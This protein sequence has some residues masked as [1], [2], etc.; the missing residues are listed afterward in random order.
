MKA[1][2]LAG[3]A[4]ISVNAEAA[5]PTYTQLWSQTEGAAVYTSAGVTFHGGNISPTASFGSWLNPPE[6]LEVVNTTTPSGMNVFAYSNGRN[7]AF[8]SDTAHRSSPVGGSI[9]TVALESAENGWG[10]C[11]IY[12]WATTGQGAWNNEAGSPNW[13]YPISNCQASVLSAQNQNIDISDDASTV[14]AAVFVN[15]TA[16]VVIQVVVLNAQTGSVQWTWTAPAGKTQYLWGIST[17]DTG[18][19]VAASINN[20]AYVLDT[21]NKVVRAIVPLDTSFVNAAA[22]STAGDIL[23]TAG[24]DHVSVYSW[25]NNKYVLSNSFAP[26]GQWYA[27]DLDLQSPVAGTAMVTVAWRDG[28]ALTTRITSYDVATGNLVIDYT[29]ATNQRLQNV[30]TVRGYGSYVLATSWGDINNVPTIVLLQASTTSTPSSVPVFSFV[31]PG[32]MFGGDLAVDSSN[33]GHDLIYVAAAGKHVPASVMGNGG[34]AYF[35]MVTN[36][37]A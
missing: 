9:D 2:F 7:V 22:I 21:S 20:N 23:A 25:S 31:T 12:G 29:S 13:N 36:P 14:A 30:A 19:F 6:F 1:L 17:S 11:N 24:A 4:A 3:L 8:Q 37:T 18:L 35:F 34:D 16:G 32:S 33:A 27:S 10:T 15:S 28:P 26:S 5:N